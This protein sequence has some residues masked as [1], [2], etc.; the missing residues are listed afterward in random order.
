MTSLKGKVAIVT[1]ARRGIGRGIA[2]AFAK[3]GAKVVVSDLNEKDCQKVVDEIKNLGSYGLAVKCDVSSSKEV[4]A[5]IKTTV[6]KFGK[7]DILVNNAGIALMKPFKD[8]TEEDWDK[9]LSVNLKSVF[10]CSK[11]VLP[12]LI[13]QGKGK[14]INIASIA[15][16]IGFAQSSAYC[17][18]KAGIINLTRVMALELAQHKINVNAIGPG[19]IKTAMTKQFL[20]DPKMKEMLLSQT[21]WGRFGKPEDIANAAVF[22][23]SDQA[24]FITGTTLFVDGGWLAK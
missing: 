13:K 16:Q 6:D 2:L 22:L 5:M 17:A 24:D 15:G 1:G 21:P 14:V 19:V 9:V 18:S 8:M 3:N 7:I 11:A 12:E 23:A 10:L 20:E 4:E